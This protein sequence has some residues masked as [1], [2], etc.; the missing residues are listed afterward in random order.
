MLVVHGHQVDPLSRSPLGRLGDAISRR[1]G[2]SALVRGGAAAAERVA[3]ALAGRR[4]V[5]AFRERALALVVREGFDLGVFGHVHVGHAAE[6]DR[7]ANAGAL[8]GE[9]LEFLELG[10]RG[11]RLRALRVGAA[12]RAVVPD[13]G[14]G[15]AR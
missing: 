8:A 5:S 6:G 7:Y 12:A 14:D 3:R 15:R 4:M 2:R 10:P 13:A 9:V 11:P 1:F